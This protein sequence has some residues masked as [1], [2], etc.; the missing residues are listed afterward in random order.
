[1]KK[2]SLFILIA[3]LIGMANMGQAQKSQLY[4][5][6]TNEKG[7]PLPYANVVILG[8]S[9]GTS[10]NF[11]GRYLLEL[12]AG[13]YEISYQ[14]V[15]YESKQHTVVIER[16]EQT[17]LDVKLAEER[18]FLDA[19][20]VKANA[21]DPAYEIIRNAQK[22]RK[23]HLNEHKNLTYK[24]YS[25]LFGKSTTDELSAVN[26]FGTMMTSKKGI[27]YLSESVAA[28]KKFDASQETEILD[29]S[30]VMGDSSKTSENR[31]IFIELYSNRPFS[32]GNQITT[33][34]IIS[35]IADDALGFYDYEFLGSMREAGQLVHKIK[36]IPKTNT[37]NTFMGE[38]YIIDGSWR[39]LKSHLFLPSI[40]LGKIEI[41]T[42]YIENEIQ[43]TWLPFASSFILNKKGGENL[44][45]HHNIFFDYQFDVT[46]PDEYKLINYSVS[47]FNLLRDAKWWEDIRP[48]AL[49]EDEKRAYQA[50]ALKVKADIGVFDFTKLE[51]DDS[52]LSLLPANKKRPAEILQTVIQTGRFPIN[53]QLSV[54]ANVFTYN[55]VEGGVIKPHVYYSMQSK[56]GRKVHFDLVTRYGFASNRF[57]SK[58]GVTYE[59]N[60][61]NLSSLRLEGGSYIEQIAGQPVVG[62]YWNMIYTLEKIN[63]QRLY[64]RDY[65]QL[66]WQ[67]EL[68]NGLDLQIG[69]SCN[70][71]HPLENN[72]SYHW[73]EHEDREFSPN[74]AFIQGEYVDFEPTTLWETTFSLSYQHRRRFDIIDGRKIP[75][76]S[77]FPKVALGADIGMLDVRYS[78]LWS[79]VGANWVVGTLGYSKLNAASGV[80][81]SSDNLSPVDLFH[82]MG[83][84]I[85]IYQQRSI[86]GI[87]YQLLPYYGYSTSTY[88]AG[89]NFE[90]DFGAAILGRVPLLKRL[91]LQSQVLAN[92]LHTAE[93]P[94]YYE[95]G[96]GL[97]SSLFPLRLSYL[98][99]FEE[100]KNSRQGLMLHM[101]IN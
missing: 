3:A 12:Q 72:A 20:V 48:M 95:L 82:F 77:D 53:K 11:D 37:G 97:S 4:G 69:T 43:S 85:S 39:I 92:F 79:S 88:F 15:G 19:V 32:I 87:A 26:F 54:G 94:V 61:L 22:Q 63:L 13:T 90:H 18:F 98:L 84:E 65:L 78:R 9:K 6:V 81:L 14:F 36:L 27:Y 58:A 75:R 30:L 41:N 44:I 99:S 16:G 38:I 67:H 25:K 47:E 51:A 17:P 86:Y 35:P 33:T 42:T 29:A 34:R 66:D 70:Q 1:M 56:R 24:A 52:L 50:A 46:I 83:N 71:R 45:Y 10:T 57:Y 89:A 60:P 80:F 31:S 40:V 7:E 96:L 28:M 74:Q 91:G 8:Q 100:Q 73:G 59:L 62:D 49:T 21:E 5:K 76:G 55:T 101:V 23:Y 68:V 93:N 2:Q 64:G